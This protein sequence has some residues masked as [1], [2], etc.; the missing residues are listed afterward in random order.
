MAEATGLVVRRLGPEDLSRYKALRDESLERHPESF[1]SD[2]Q[3][4]RT[5][6]PESYLGR[7]GLSEPLGGT[8]LFGAWMNGEL[9]GSVAC[10]REFKPKTRHRA[11]IVG[12]YVRESQARQG[13]GRQLLAA[14]I[15]Q[16]RRAQGLELLT[17]T[18]TASNERALRMYERAGFKVYGVQPRAIRVDVGPRTQ[19][20]DKAHMVLVL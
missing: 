1:T 14:C 2:A 3:S 20:F 10:E 17:L 16:A 11:K 7:L 18:V 15:A 19:Y 4:E 12:M 8:F 9:V 13:I 5:R 6:S